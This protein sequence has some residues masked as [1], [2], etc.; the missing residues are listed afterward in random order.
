[1]S[2][3]MEVD[4]P[5]HHVHFSDSD[6]GDMFPK[7][8]SEISIVKKCPGHVSVH[9]GFLKHRHRYDVAFNLT[10]EVSEGI[11]SN[12]AVMPLTCNLRQENVPHMCC[13]LKSCVDE[14]PMGLRFNV[15]FFAHKERLIR[16]EILISDES[17]G[18][19][20]RMEMT[21]RVLGKG[22][23]TPSLKRGVHILSKELDEES[24]A[25]DWH[26]FE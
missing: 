2:T 6:G 14:G 3:H 11:S 8:H 9:L 4:V 7:D 25:S 19:Q 17:T 5:D 13:M 24:D 26:G 18:A 23:G 16:E 15:E 1:M 12:G 22:K 21:A 20:L 10:R